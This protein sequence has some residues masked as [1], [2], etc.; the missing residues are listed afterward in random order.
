[1]GGLFV[2]PFYVE[3]HVVQELES[4]LVQPVLSL[5]LSGTWARHQKRTEAD[6]ELRCVSDFRLQRG[7]PLAYEIVSLKLVTRTD[8]QVFRIAQPM[9][10]RIAAKNKLNTY[11]PVLWLNHVTV[12][13][14]IDQVRSSPQLSLSLLAACTYKLIGLVGRSTVEADAKFEKG[15]TGRIGKMP[16]GTSCRN[17][18]PIASCGW[19]LGKV[20]QYNI[21]CEVVV[22]TESDDLLPVLW[23]RLYERDPLGNTG[24][25]LRET[26]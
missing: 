16:H 20:L 8:S 1:M 21:E 14:E 22:T 26:L 15:L 5:P 7:R 9:V 18:D 24:T 4:L 3:Q 11:I 23:K 10:L 17:L 6:I 12:G 25:L 13:L 19:S 2:D